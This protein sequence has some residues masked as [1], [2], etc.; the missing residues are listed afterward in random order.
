[1]RSVQWNAPELCARTT[2][3]AFCVQHFYRWT[4]QVKCDLNIE[5]DPDL[6]LII[7]QVHV[8]QLN[9]VIAKYIFNT[10]TF[11]DLGKKSKKLIK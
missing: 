11:T 2:R 5:C 3:T 8:V 1:M 7:A 9:W 10:Y 6:M 4:D